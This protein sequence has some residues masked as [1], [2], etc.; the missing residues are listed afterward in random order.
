MNHPTLKT[1]KLL[2][3]SPSRRA[4]LISRRSTA[5]RGK[6]A[7]NRFSHRSACCNRRQGGLIL[8][9]QG[10]RG[11]SKGAKLAASQ[12]RQLAAIEFCCHGHLHS[13]LGRFQKALARRVLLNFTR[14]SLEFSYLAPLNFTGISLEFSDFHQ[15]FSRILLKFHQNFTRILC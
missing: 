9:W 11:S 10:R 4:A 14:I 8:G 5:M 6:E 12:G 15:N 13:S 7:L 2:S 3:S 1:K